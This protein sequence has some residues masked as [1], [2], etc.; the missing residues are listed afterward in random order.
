LIDLHLHTTASDG[1]CTPEQLVEQ[2][3]AAGVTTLAVT[4]HDTTAAIA[5]AGARC[6]EG[7]MTLV[8]GIEITAMEAARDVH[9]LGYFFDPAHEGLQAFLARA[10]AS[11]LARVHAIIERLASL[12]VP[13]DT[14]RFFGDAGKQD[15]RSIGRPQVARALVEAGHAS[16]V[17]DAFDRWLARGRPGFVPRSGANPEEVIAVIHE[18]GGLASLAHP[19]LADMDAR[20]PQLRDAGLDALEAY[21]SDHDR[22]TRDRYLMLARS[23]EL[24]VTGGS[25]YHGDPAH[26]LTPGTVTLPAQEWERLSTWPRRSS[27]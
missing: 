3:A 24:L 22:A 21:H 11:R 5:V 9:I 26:G 27:R 15:G 12:G 7:G 16:D 4:D 14:T 1:L 8:P 18:A 6:A 20:I 19:V 13:V 25:D 10:R 23:L 17:N 2:A